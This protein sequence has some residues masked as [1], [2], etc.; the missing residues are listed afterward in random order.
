[1]PSTSPSTQPT[2]RQ[3]ID[4]V[5]GAT[6]GV[7]NGSPSS[8][9]NT[10]TD[11]I[12]TAL[13]PADLGQVRA[14]ESTPWWNYVGFTSTST[15]TGTNIST[16][17]RP[18]NDA[19]VAFVANANQE[20]IPTTPSLTNG[21]T[22]P[23]LTT[24]MG[25]AET[26]ESGL[27]NE[28]EDGK[29]A[30]PTEKVKEEV[31]SGDQAVPW[32]SSWG[33]YSSTKANGP[34]QPQS[35]G[36]EV[37]TIS[38]DPQADVPLFVS[39]PQQQTSAASSE[40]HEGQDNTPSASAH[41]SPHINPI[42]TSMEANSG[43][44]ASFFSS[45]SLMVKTLGYGGR[46]HVQDVKRDEDGMEVM[47]LD[48]DKNERRD[49]GEGALSK[50]SGREDGGRSSPI[51][52]SESR[53]NQDSQLELQISDSTGNKG[54]Q[55]IVKSS[56]SSTPEKGNALIPVTIPPISSP[57]SRDGNHTESLSKTTTVSKNITYTRTVSPAPSKKSVS[58]Q[59]P[60]P[61]LVLP[62]WEQI[63]NT[64]PRNMVPATNIPERYSEDQTVGG[65]LLGKTMSFVSGV[66]FS[67][68]TRHGSPE[69][70]K[71][72]KGKDREM[73][74][75]SDIDFKKWKEERFREFGKELP[76]SWQIVEGGLDADATPTTPMNNIP[77]FGLGSNKR[78][79]IGVGSSGIDGYED[80]SHSFGM[81]DVLRGCK[82]VVVI[83]IH[84]WFP[85]AFS[86]QLL[87]D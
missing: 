30:E 43:G 26:C 12:R 16:S 66:L 86:I 87:S 82:R 38:E 71:Q 50:D 31:Q 24:N 17:T 32:Y 51:L 27:V 80:K 5:A 7:D 76:K 13:D 62:T 70:E 25:S 57:S 84:G 3:S 78:S 11:T 23:G 9:A 67:K 75:N 48:D 10:I 83:G 56:L 74:R 44:W 65:K 14:N 46:R 8:E 35:E 77:I 15:S 45:N 60:P 58:S 42:T 68:D 59:P 52:V 47:D 20:S 19:A 61:N 6:H 37:K 29:S 28:A 81:K 39:R 22:N 49:V 33:W 41:P 2:L 69:S 72:M 21:N 85:G 64:A 54:D 55:S 34:A 1:V 18:L 73:D 40:T 36:L 4:S 53:P 79:Q 63:F